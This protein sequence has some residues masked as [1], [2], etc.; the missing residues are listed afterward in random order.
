RY[1][2][3]PRYRDKPA[4]AAVESERA[5]PPRQPVSRVAAAGGG[6]AER[7]YFDP[8]PMTERRAPAGLR[9][10]AA[11]ASFNARFAPAPA[12]APPGAAVAAYA[13]AMPRAE[14]VMTGRGLY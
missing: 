2:G 13:P 5:P 11:S 10:E 7:E 3:G 6:G 8:Q 14:A 1:D 4:Y 12:A 9:R